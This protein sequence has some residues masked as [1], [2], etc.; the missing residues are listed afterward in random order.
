MFHIFN[1]E[2]G[3]YILGVRALSWVL[4]VAYLISGGGLKINRDFNA[5][6]TGVVELYLKLNICWFLRL[7]VRPKVGIT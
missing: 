2:G 3:K 6:H 5:K 7:V 4:F 1:G